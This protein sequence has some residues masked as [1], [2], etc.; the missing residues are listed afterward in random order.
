[1][2]LKSAV[3]NDNHL[4]QNYAM[5]L[6]HNLQISAWPFSQIGYYYLIQ[7]ILMNIFVK[8]FNFWQ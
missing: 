7:H 3:C 6:S 1:M 5:S 2:K 8:I 4:K